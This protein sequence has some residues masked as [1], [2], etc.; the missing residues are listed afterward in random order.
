MTFRDSFDEMLTSI[1]AP[2]DVC[3][4]TL[5]D[6]IKLD[7]HFKEFFDWAREVN[8]PVVVLSGGME[9]I[10]KA[11]L[12]HLLGPEADV[13]QIVSNDVGPKDGKSINEERGWKIIFHDDT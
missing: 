7:P 8:M 12:Y 9:P 3:V 2:F 10:I 4:Q 13:I 1:D 11:L 5:I 6:N